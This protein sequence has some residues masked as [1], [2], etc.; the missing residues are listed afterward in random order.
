MFF[1]YIGAVL[2]FAFCCT[3]Q[4]VSHM[5]HLNSN[6]VSRD[7]SEIDKY[8]LHFDSFNLLLSRD[9]ERDVFLVEC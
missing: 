9:F 5:Y 7:G 1:M 6:N 4:F 8:N 3:L 2:T